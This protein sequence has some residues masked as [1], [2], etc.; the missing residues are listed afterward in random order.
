M[1]A[2]RPPPEWLLGAADVFSI[3]SCVLLLMYL[4]NRL[5]CNKFVRLTLSLQVAFLLLALLAY[6]R[7]S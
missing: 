3:A 2:A 7:Y 4:L 6:W 5:E 1:P